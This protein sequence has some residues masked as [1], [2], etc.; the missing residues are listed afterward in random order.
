M[1]DTTKAFLRRAALEAIAAQADGA[2]LD[3][4]TILNGEQPAEVRRPALSV[5]PAAREVIEGPA[6]D[7]HYWARFIRENF[8]P[9]MTGNARLRFTS[10]ELLTWLENCRD[11][12]MTTGDVEAHATGR[13]TWRN[14]VSAALASLKRQGAINAPAFG[15]EYL[16]CP[17]SRP[18]SQLTT[19]NLLGLA[20]V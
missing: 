8:I 20:G 5:L 3:L 1:N 10:H 11:L 12:T 14:A 15:K 9:F 6:R 2:A 16:I 13:E 18:T 7:Y 19:E 17:P 4:L